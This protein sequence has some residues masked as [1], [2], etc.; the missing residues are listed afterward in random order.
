MFNLFPVL[1]SRK[2]RHN[3]V[4][5]NYAEKHLQMVV[6]ELQKVAARCQW[7]PGILEFSP[8]NF[9]LAIGKVSISSL[10]IGMLKLTVADSGRDHGIL[11]G[12]WGQRI[13]L[14]SPSLFWFETWWHC[15]LHP[16][17]FTSGFLN[18]NVLGQ[19]FPE[20]YHCTPNLTTCKYKHSCVLRLNA[21]R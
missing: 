4:L 6:L 19:S 17:R 20:H 10:H 12:Y 16:T 18:S 7:D 5:T 2:T 11:L 3:N 15:N 13:L 1:V 21:Q 14:P 9:I 8:G